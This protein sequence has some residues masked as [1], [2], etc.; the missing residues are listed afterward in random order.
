MPS[1]LAAGIVLLFSQ[2]LRLSGQERTA[3]HFMATLT[4]LAVV[5]LPIHSSIADRVSW[6][7]IPLQI[8]IFSRAS[9]LNLA[10]PRKLVEIAV[11]AVFL[12]WMPAWLLIGDR[13]WIVPYRSYLQDPQ[14][15]LLTAPTKPHLNAVAGSDFVV[16][17]K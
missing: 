10:A 5:L 6:Y 4:A 1:L 12:V 8:M 16:S 15:L 3:C 9:Y 7:A 11:A 17:P 14:G 2:F 13:S